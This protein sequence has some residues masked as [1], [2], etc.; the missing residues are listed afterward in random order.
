MAASAL[1]SIA[2]KKVLRSPSA[3]ANA[4]DW[5]KASGGVATAMT[6]DVHADRIGLALATLPA[7]A[8]DNWLYRGPNHSSDDSINHNHNHNHNHTP[9]NSHYGVSC[10]VLDSISLIASEE[11]DSDRIPN[12]MLGGI[13]R[14][15]KRAVTPDA[16]R[17]L[18]GL[19]R[20]HNVCGFVVS[21]PVQQDTGLRGASCGRTLWAL[22][23]LLSEDNN[24]VDND[25]DGA[26]PGP[27]FAPHRP[28]CFWDGVHTEQPTHDAFGRCS[29][30]AR[31]APSTQTEHFA[32]KE[33]Y[34]KD[35][36]VLAE[37]VWKDF[38]DH[39]WPTPV[40]NAHSVT[41][42][43]ETVIPNLKPKPTR[44]LANCA[45]SRHGG[46]LLSARR[47]TLVAA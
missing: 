5:K 47:R 20:D 28:L 43:T 39:H 36:S 27:L 15:R 10:T 23:Q 32:S 45:G 8:N 18:E 1:S 24:D 46:N 44:I 21:W 11:S 16:K 37:E 40:V 29:V 6:I 41:V 26:R 25:N 17:R 4:L 30:F 31:T 38:C 12:A 42:E 34:H 9:G 3:V 19:I 22:E 14:R 2:L 7:H 13:G 33:Q 35:E